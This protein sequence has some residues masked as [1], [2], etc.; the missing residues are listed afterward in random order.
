MLNLT[1]L[2][3]RATHAALDAMSIPSDMGVPM[4]AAVASQKAAHSRHRSP[5]F[6]A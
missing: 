6:K 4:A 1:L 5:A 2:N 3:A